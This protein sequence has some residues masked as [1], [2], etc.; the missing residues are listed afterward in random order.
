MI[1]EGTKEVLDVYYRNATMGAQAIEAVLKHSQHPD[2]RALLEKQL[3]AYRE[4][5]SKTLDKFAMHGDKPTDNPAWLK[6]FSDFSIKLQALVDESDANLAK[7]MVEGTNMGVI[8]L[9]Q[10][11][12]AHPNLSQDV[13]ETGNAILKRENAYMESLK[14]FL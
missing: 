4:Q 1:D 12:H 13:E 9:L 11:M 10:T 2:F 8:T 14:K 3:A 6:M 5:Q 7:M